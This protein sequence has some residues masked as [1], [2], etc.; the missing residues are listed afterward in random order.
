MSARR[1]FHGSWREHVVVAKGTSRSY[2]PKPA[3]PIRTV[4]RRC[5]SWRISRRELSE[6]QPELASLLKE[7]RHSLW[8]WLTERRDIAERQRQRTETVE[9]AI[10]VFVIVGVFFDVL[11]FCQE[12]HWLP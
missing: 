6:P 8:L 11:L 10:L 3:R 5:L 12:R 9:I 1:R 2:S 7:H 4:W